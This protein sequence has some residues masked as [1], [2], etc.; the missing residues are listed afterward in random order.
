VRCIFCSQDRPPSREHIFPLAIGGTITTERV[1]TSCN[2]ILGSRVDSALN[3]FLPVRARRAELQLAGNSGEPPSMFEIFLGD[4]KLI[5][6]EASRIRTSLNKATGKLDHRQLYHA[7]DVVTPDGKKARQI[8]L[9]ERDKDQIPKIIQ[10]ERKRH[11]LPPLSMEELAIKASEFTVNAVENPLVQVNISV[12]FAFLRHAMMKIAYEFAFLWLGESYLDD[13]LA[14]KL[15]EAILSEDLASTDSLAGYV[16]WAESC[17]VFQYWT[18]HKAHHLAFASVQSETVFVAVRVFDIYAVGIPV[19]H[20]I[21][22]HS[23]IG[24]DGMDAP[25][26]V[27]DA[28]TG[29]TIQTTFGE[30]QRRLACAMTTHAR[31]PPFPDPLSTDNAND[32]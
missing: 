24:V 28:A 19:S 8:T 13:P 4:Q 16:G 32:L 1:C 9:D 12:S 23:G 5:G 27:I 2:S 6:P 3:N 26:L 11:G 15:R 7:T 25:F 18:P 17:G 20:H 21:S 10:R 30:E 29:R 31:K 14:A 22:R